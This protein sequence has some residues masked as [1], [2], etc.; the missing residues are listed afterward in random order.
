MSN[1]LDEL[2]QLYSQLLVEYPNGLSSTSTSK[3][4][5]I[6][7]FFSSWLEI[8]QN[9][10]YATGAGTRP[11]N[12]E[13]RLSQGL[14]A[15]K[16][17][18]LGL[19]FLYD[20]KNTEDNRIKLTDSALVTIEKFLGRGKAHY[21]GILIIVQSGSEIFVTNIAYGSR[22]G[23]I[24]T[25]ISEF[26]LTGFQV[27]MITDSTDEIINDS[28]SND[29]PYNLIYFGAP[30]TG[31]SYKINQYANPNNSIRVTFHPDTDYSTFVGAY[32]PTEING[33]LTYTFVEQQFLNVY[34]KAWQR[35]E[36]E[37]V[38]LIIEELNRGN[39]AQIFGDIFQLMERD[40]EGYSAYPIDADADLAKYLENYFT[41][42]KSSG[43]PE[44]LLKAQRYYDYFGGVFNRISLPNNL[45]IH[46]T[47]NTSDQSLFPID[48]AFKRRW[49]WEYIPINF[50]NESKD[51]QI[52]ISDTVFSW[53][54]FLQIVNK[55]IEAV[56][57]SEDK[58]IGQFFIKTFNKIIP[59]N[60]LRSKVMF[61]I[62]NDVL[63][64]EP[65][66]SEKYFFRSS[67]QI[68]GSDYFSFNDL[69]S[70]F[71]LDILKGFMNY[72]GITPIGPE[73]VDPEIT[74]ISEA[75]PEI[76]VSAES[77]N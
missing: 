64:D 48:S 21:D 19:A 16:H 2:R 9:E 14:Q 36:N 13:V 41:K 1:K 67:F 32:K 46:A 47:M 58:K 18:K 27:Q 11:G 62:W 66:T 57:D 22:L 20:D 52:M 43:V 29:L 6:K 74:E 23:F 25:I 60:T 45:L 31:K 51:Y 30:G 75:Q 73:T 59:A 40:S 71:G 3:F 63:K 68:E 37:N 28:I 33:Q 49:D 12:L 56:N 5:G 10:I 26:G 55:K 38:Y 34:L 24:E 7:R 76:S 77:S 44:N 42:L 50:E 65:K 39:C 72:L 8:E 70:E 61:Y 35:Q 15:T 4:E 69:Y 53:K 54:E 17:T